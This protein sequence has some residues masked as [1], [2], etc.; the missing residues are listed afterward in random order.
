LSNVIG[1]I[2]LESIQ[3]NNIFGGSS[4][5]STLS[6]GSNLQGP[7]SPTSVRRV[8]FA[9]EPA[10]THS[11]LSE[12]SDETLRQRGFC[13]CGDHC[14]LFSNFGD[15]RSA[16]RLLNS[17]VYESHSMEMGE[18]STEVKANITTFSDDNAGFENGF[19]SARDDTYYVADSPE[20]DIQKFFSRPVRIA[21]TSWTVGTA[22]TPLSLQVFRLFWRDKR[23]VN[24]LNNYQNMKCDMCVK[25][26]IN[27][28]PFHYGML[29]A[30][31]LP[32]TRFD[33]FVNT[34]LTEAG[35]VRASQNP[36]VFLDPTSSTG[37]CLRLPYTHTFNCYNVTSTTELDS[38]GTLQIR[39][40][41]GLSH[42][43]G[44]IE[45][46]TVSVIAWAENIVLGA[47]TFNSAGG[48]VAQSGDEYGE[49]V[50]SRP[51]F[52][53]AKIA[54][55]LRNVPFIG[56][57]AMSTS[58]GARNL[59][60]IAQ[61]FGHV[62]PN[63]VSDINFMNPRFQPNMA[64]ATQHDPIFKATL[65]DKQ[66]VTIDP[67]V[68]G[69]TGRDEMSIVDIAKRESYITQ[70]NWT[71]TGAVDTRLFST[72]VTPNMWRVIGT[73][74]NAQYLQTPASWVATPFQYWRGTMRFRFTAVAST[75][76]R[77]RVRIVYEPGLGLPTVGADFN[78]NLTQIWDLSESKEMVIDVGWH[79]PYSYAP[80]SNI[81][82]LIIPFSPT[83]T[84]NNPVIPFANGSL[85]I[86]V[87]N[88]LTAP[89]SNLASPI[90]ILMSVSMCDDF[91]VYSPQDT[92]TNL[93]YFVQSGEAIEEVQ[94][95]PHRQPAHVVF[96]NT[97]KD[98]ATPAIYYG[99]PVL[100][101][102][103]LLKRYT[104]SATWGQ[105]GTGAVARYSW[106]VNLP[107]FPLYPGR[108]PLAVHAATTPINFVS[109]TFLNYFT[110]AFLARRGGVRHRF[111]PGNNDVFLGNVTL[112]RA[113]GA[114]YSNTLTVTPALA[115]P[116]NIARSNRVDH[117]GVRNGA[118]GWNTTPLIADTGID[119]EAPFH[120]I[121]RYWPARAGAANDITF[122]NQGISIFAKCAQTAAG[123]PAFTL[124]H[125]VSAADDFAL[126]GFIDVPIMYIHATQPAST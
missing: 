105:V 83:A 81:Q 126:I 18:A 113:V 69:L 55:S 87:L 106:K 115:N 104:Y 16:A 70:F 68:V 40:L 42:V 80:I 117:Y 107:Q 97:L 120:T 100:S 22:F 32:D 74:I 125:Y 67:R 51:A 71:Q 103:T 116:S 37:G 90:T 86:Y 61:I 60:K 47:P 76:H 5:P 108:A 34:D 30:N 41:V 91:E 52:I 23:N 3:N 66:E 6:N 75:F 13:V 39:E 88:E 36:H 4:N 58:M 1:D 19:I 114:A 9:L 53:L 110:P 64:S 79:Q 62:K 14:L 89:D 35:C 102:R 12:G 24:R 122:N 111:V 33:S 26:L 11:E 21:T 7:D 101:L 46:V 59:G 56:P 63:I 27:G 25:I 119:I 8:A 50:V 78:T 109:N 121:R 93:E 112:G 28:T 29:L 72:L 45:P 10:D 99:D 38:A 65:D 17:L 92:M 82:D 118:S 57:Y 15:T 44:V 85:A 2:L 98:D 31:V 73:G 96:G 84:V 95:S 20:F 124:D 48:L 49:G 43:S 94:F 123:F 54:G 77:G